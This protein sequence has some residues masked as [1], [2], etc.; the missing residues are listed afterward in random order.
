[1]LTVALTLH[2]KV[3]RTFT[4]KQLKYDWL[5]GFWNFLCGF[6]VFNAVCN[7]FS[8]KQNR[9]DSYSRCHYVGYDDEDYRTFG[10]GSSCVDDYLEELDDLEMDSYLYDDYDY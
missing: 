8:S 5:M 7:L 3:I 10:A 9:T 6:A 2:V 4:C 1:M